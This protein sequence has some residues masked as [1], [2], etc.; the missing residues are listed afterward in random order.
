MFQFPLIT[1]S[2]RNRQTRERLPIADLQKS[3]KETLVQILKVEIK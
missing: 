1:I 3:F 2:D